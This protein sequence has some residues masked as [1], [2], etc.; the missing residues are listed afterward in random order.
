MM[1]SATLRIVTPLQQR[2]RIMEILHSIR[3]PIK[4]EPGCIG[5][6]IHQDIDNKNVITLEEIWQSQKDLERHIRSECYRSILTLMDMSSKTPEIRFNTIAYSAGIEVV[7][8]I[9]GS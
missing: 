5:L 6:N 7:Q 9:R 4:L 3:E 1:I 2:K 8:A